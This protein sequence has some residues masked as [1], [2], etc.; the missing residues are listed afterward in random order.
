MCIIRMI[1]VTGSYN[2]ML[3]PTLSHTLNILLCTLSYETVI[4]ITL[5]LVLCERLLALAG[6]KCLFKDKEVHWIDIV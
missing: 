1:V 2:V 6:A 4:I 5:I 3:S